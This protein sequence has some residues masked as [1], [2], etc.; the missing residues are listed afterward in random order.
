MFH[1][2]TKGCLLVGLAV[3]LCPAGH[4][5]STHNPVDSD[6]RMPART[7]ILGRGDAAALEEVVEHQNAVGAA[8]WVGIQGKGFLTYP[9]ADLGPFN[10]TLSILH[11]D[12]FRLDVETPQGIRSTRIHGS[13]G[14]I[15][16]ADAK[17]QQIQP[18]TATQGL[19]QFHLL[20]LPSFPG[21]SLSLI[22]R[23]TTQIQGKSLHLITIESPLPKDAYP[24]GLAHSTT[25][26]D[27]YFDPSTHLLVKSATSVMVTGTHGQ[28]FLRVIS[29]SDYQK[30]GG[31][32]I[33]FHY[34]E[35]LSG[36]L[37][38]TLQL[39]QASYETP[40]QPSDFIF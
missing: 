6:A 27:L 20:R 4:T 19:V 23:G 17:Y 31:T 29:Y 18:E 3:T 40:L 39:T 8:P 33:P 35:S 36:Q 9:S 21:P 24:I 22:D 12:N 28:D 13:H 25:A 10:A 30:V 7:G 38:W 26:T 37:Q 32:M 5:Q 1:R 34:E 14:A 2:F 15:Q 16:D 11:G